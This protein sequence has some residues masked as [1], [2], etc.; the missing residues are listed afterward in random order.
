M[1]SQRQPGADQDRPRRTRCSRSA[2]WPTRPYAVYQPGR[3]QDADTQHKYQSLEIP[4]GIANPTIGLFSNTYA[5][6]NATADKNFLN[7]VNEIV[8]GRKPF[9]GSDDLITPGGAGRGDGM[10]TEYEEQLQTGGHHAGDTADSARSSCWRRVS[11]RWPSGLQPR[12]RPARPGVRLPDPVRQR[13]L[14]LVLRSVLADQPAVSPARTRT[15]A[16]PVADLLRRGAARTPPTRPRRRTPRVSTGAALSVTGRLNHRDFTWPPIMKTTCA[17]PD[18]STVR[19]SA[20][21]AAWTS[22]PRSEHGR[23]PTGPQSG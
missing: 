3:P 15:V 22:R 17:D 14:R 12:W 18:G 6:K 11:T 13:L 2:T 19:W 1:D 20:T 16:A 23:R 21:V 7:G 10:R 9:A 5:T 4:T 8:Q